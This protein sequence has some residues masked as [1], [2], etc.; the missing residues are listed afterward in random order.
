MPKKVKKP[1]DLL[2]LKVGE[3]VVVEEPW[4]VEWVKEKLKKEAKAGIRG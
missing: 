4:E 2:K 1:E 3:S